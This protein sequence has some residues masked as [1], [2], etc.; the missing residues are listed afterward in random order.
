MVGK[1]AGGGEALD[2][3]Q[4]VRDKLAVVSDCGWGG[5]CSSLF[6]RE[7]EVGGLGLECRGSEEK[8]ALGRF[9]LDALD[10]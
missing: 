10:E 9:H 3:C 6:S 7:G 4:R 8:E 2:G 5:D 1:D